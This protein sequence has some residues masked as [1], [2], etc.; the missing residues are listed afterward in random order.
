[1]RFLASLVMI[2]LLISACTAGEDV[3]PTSSNVITS[4]ATPDP[5]QMSPTPPDHSENIAATY[6]ATEEVDENGIVI[7]TPQSQVLEN[8]VALPGTMVYDT[9]YEDLNPVKDF[10]RITFVRSGGGQGAESY[11]L[12]L[13]NDGKYTLN[14]LEGTVPQATIAGINKILDDIN[15]F[16]INTPMVGPSTETDN[17]RYTITVYQGTQELT[18]R[19]E[20]KFAPQEIMQLIG[21]LTAVIIGS[22]T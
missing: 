11:L 14:D 4:D 1:M 13:Y 9:E 6:S 18:V 21:A 20:D 15:F 22:G 7:V 10:D 5:S 17:Y 16:A 8:Q 3:P 19:A 2:V 12:K